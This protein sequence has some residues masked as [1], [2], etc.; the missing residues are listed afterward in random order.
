MMRDELE[1]GGRV[2]VVYPVIEVSE[3]L[4]ELRAAES[5]FETLTKEF[6]DFQCGL[7]HGRMKVDKLSF[8]FEVDILVR[9][10]CQFII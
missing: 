1:S 3:E 8:R 5:E 2:F 7:V 4:P 10:S 9:Y 6:K